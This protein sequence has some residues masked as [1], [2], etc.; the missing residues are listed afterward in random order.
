M[1]SGMNLSSAFTFRVEDSLL[2]HEDRCGAFIRSD[3]KYASNYTASFF[4]FS[5]NFQTSN[6]HGAVTAHLFFSTLN[7]VSKP[8][9]DRGST[10]FKALCYK[11]EGRWVDPKWCNWNFSLT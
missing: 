6:F 2:Y 7:I 1:Y 3:A 4:V 5:T 8:N 10:V 9:G 11:A